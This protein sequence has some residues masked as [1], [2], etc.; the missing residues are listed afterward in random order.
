MNL[1]RAAGYDVLSEYYVN[2]AGNQIDYLAESINA[3]YLQ[4]NGIDAEIPDDGYHGQ[5]IVETARHILERN[6]WTWMKRKGFPFSRNW[7]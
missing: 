6:T 7:D 3:R 4:L 2:D 5:D 1:L